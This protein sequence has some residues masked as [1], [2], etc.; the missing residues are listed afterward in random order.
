MF[1]IGWSELVIIGVVALIVIG[2]KELP[3]VLRMAG[4]WIGKVRR[5]ASDFQGQ[6]NEAMREAEMADLKKQVDEFADST[7]D[8]A[9]DFDPLKSMEDSFDDPLA[10]AKAAEADATEAGGASREA[11]QSAL[12]SP[13]ETVPEAEP[14]HPSTEPAKPSS[15]ETTSSDADAT[16]PPPKTAAGG[17][18]A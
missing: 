1:D 8:M 2:P 13:D 9:S 5:M 10:D 12:P 16:P 14:S 4:Q 7:R 18:S 3:G 11:A 6:F 17:V 15:T